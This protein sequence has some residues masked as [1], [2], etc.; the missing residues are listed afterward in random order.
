LQKRES[1]S[2]T[3]I[4]EGLAIPHIIVKGS[5]KFD[6]AIFRSRDGFRFNGKKVHIV[7]ALAGS[8]DERTFHLKALMAIAQ[9]VQNKNFIDSWMKAKD[10][11][12]LRNL[13][14]LA[15]RIRSEQL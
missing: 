10:A 2:T 12:E 4:H 6:I 15:E 9:I 14:L 7:F 5:G 1:D 8:I 13:I 11:A 3:V